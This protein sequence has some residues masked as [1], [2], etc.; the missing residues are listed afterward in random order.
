MGGEG[1]GRGGTKGRGAEIKR[2]GAAGREAKKGRVTT[3][4]NAGR[5]F[6]IDKA[7]S[8]LSFIC[9]HLKKH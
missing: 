3:K 6:R 9:R 8:V 2:R 7:H 1:R 4:V 5:A